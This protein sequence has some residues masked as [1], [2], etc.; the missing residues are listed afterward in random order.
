MPVCQECEAPF[1]NRV[2]IEGKVRVLSTRKRCLACSPFG[3]HNTRKVG[4]VEDG[5]ERCSLCHQRKPLEDFYLCRNGRYY[6]YCKVCDRTRQTSRKREVK[7]AAVG[8]LGGSCTRCGYDRHVAGLDFHHTDPSTKDFTLGHYNGGLQG[9][10]LTANL[11]AELDKC[12][13]VCSNCH[14]EIHAGALP[15]SL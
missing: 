3:T 5:T 10:E 15:F 9:G 13:L 6:A 4:A 2:R 14:R 11:K 12:E 1:P 8:Y 7:T